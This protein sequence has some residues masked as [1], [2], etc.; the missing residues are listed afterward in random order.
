MCWDG[1]WRK[2]DR[3]DS[4]QSESAWEVGCDGEVDR[5]NLVWVAGSLPAEYDE[6]V[7][8]M[9]LGASPSS[10]SCGGGGVVFVVALLIAALVVSLSSIVVASLP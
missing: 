8:V 10:S 9:S 3:V 4:W 2:C 5:R 7:V 1:E 6:V